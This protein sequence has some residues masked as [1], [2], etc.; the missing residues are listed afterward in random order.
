MV[1]LGCA[2]TGTVHGLSRLLRGGPT[3]GSAGPILEVGGSASNSANK[4]VH[5]RLQGL[6]ALAQ[7]LSGS[8][9]RR[10]SARP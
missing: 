4:Q 2:G 7:V 9:P 6:A 3:W 8:K 5:S 1:C 10:S